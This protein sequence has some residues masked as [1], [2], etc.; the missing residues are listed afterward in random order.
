M[1]IKYLDFT[2][3]VQNDMLHKSQLQVSD[4]CAVLRILIAVVAFA[5]PL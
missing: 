4:W 3:I 1:I 2:V 5:A